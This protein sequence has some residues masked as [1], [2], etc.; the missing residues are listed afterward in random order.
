MVSRRQFLGGLG[1][2]TLGS[3]S[4]PYAA[5]HDV[6]GALDLVEQPLALEHLPPSFDRYRIGFISD[7]HH[8]IYMRDEWILHAAELLREARVDLVVLG[9]DYLWIPESTLARNIPNCSKPKV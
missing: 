7:L 5:T 2:A 1:I 4:L 9:G 3:L 8:G 6:T